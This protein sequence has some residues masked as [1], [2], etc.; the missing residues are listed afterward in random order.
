MTTLLTM[1]QTTLQ[2]TE[3]WDEKKR[4]AR[5]RELARGERRSVQLHF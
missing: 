3:I 2:L 5:E 4:L 1:P